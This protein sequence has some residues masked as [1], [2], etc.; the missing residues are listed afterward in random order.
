MMDILYLGRVGYRS[1]KF[2]PLIFFSGRRYQFIG[3][4]LG[5]GGVEVWRQGKMANK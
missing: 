1:L 2:F 4:R 5:M 3:C